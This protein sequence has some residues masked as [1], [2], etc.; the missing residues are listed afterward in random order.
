MDSPYISDTI[1]MLTDQ[2]YHVVSMWGGDIQ[3][4]D[5]KIR[6]L[7]QQD[8]S[9]TII[10]LSVLDDVTPS[11]FN[12][13]PNVYI[14]RT[15]ILKSR[16]GPQEFILPYIYEPLKEQM[17]VLKKGVRPRI[18]F[19]GQTHQLERRTAINILSSTSRVDREFLLRSS[20]WGGKPHDPIVVSEFNQNMASSEFNLCVRGNGNFSMR[21][22]QTLSA[23]RIPVII[24]SETYLPWE[25]SIPWNEIAVIINE[26]DDL[27]EKIVHFWE[28]HDI[29][30]VQQL[31][32]DIYWHHM[33]GK[34]LANNMLSYLL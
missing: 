8:P 33:S 7:L 9:A 15:S 19:C 4:I 5:A 10:G 2:G 14:L 6:T 20:F 12:S 28:S 34:G 24:Q 32:H 3:V 26:G 18:A 30:H 25:E 17:P 21:L 23:G 31:C 11:T 27:I 16:K 13:T 1:S 29:E 22:Y